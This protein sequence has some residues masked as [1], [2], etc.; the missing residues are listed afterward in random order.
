MIRFDASLNIRPT[1]DAARERLF[2]WLRNDISGA[3]CLDLFAGSG[4]LGF[5][6]ISRGAASIVFVDK[7]R[8]V[9]R[10]LYQVTEYLESDL[11]T[12][13]HQD[14]LTYLKQNKQKF[15]VVFLDPP[16]FKNLV[17]PSLDLLVSNKLLHVGAMVYVE[18]E[19]KFDLPQKYSQWKTV[20]YIQAGN[21]AYS[22]L[23][24]DSSG[25]VDEAE[26]RSLNFDY[27]DG[28]S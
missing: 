20:H 3:H 27:A 9:I 10:Y 12:I 7:N 6:A 16:F 23:Q 5:E 4:A 11:H 18:T 1:T 22:L 2:N 15:D 28:L 17:I 25:T 26:C 14:A 21:R 19:R 8:R 13:F 24:Y